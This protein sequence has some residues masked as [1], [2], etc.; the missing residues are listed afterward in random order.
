MLGNLNQLR[1]A[2]EMQKI[3]EQEVTDVTEDGVRI[4]LRGDFK[5]IL[6]EIDGDRDE[7]LEKALDK[8]L[9]Q[10]L[11]QSTKKLQG[12]VGDIKF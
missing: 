5:V 10:V 4:K 3:M 8:A 12:M 2:R 1:K 7:K 11:L 9:K 6:I